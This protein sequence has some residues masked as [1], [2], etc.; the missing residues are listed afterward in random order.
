MNQN[1]PNKERKIAGKFK[2]FRILFW[3]NGKLFRRNIWG[4][5][6]EILMAFLFVL[7]ILL[8][9][10]FVDSSAYSDQNAKLTG[11]FDRLNTSNRTLIYY[12]PNNA[13]IQ[14]LVMNSVTLISNRWP[15]FQFVSGFFFKIKNF[16]FSSNSIIVILL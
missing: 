8:L 3:K 1:E 6:G 12:Y 14:E 2:Q 16:Y 13:F 4:T 10:F 15:Q 11:V 9:R 7:M 5:L